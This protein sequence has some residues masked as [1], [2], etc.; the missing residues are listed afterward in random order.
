[1]N[2]DTVSLSKNGNESATAEQ[3]EKGG[4]CAGAGHG[5]GGTD[6]ECAL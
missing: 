1:M 2:K 6:G 3:L 5:V 4:A